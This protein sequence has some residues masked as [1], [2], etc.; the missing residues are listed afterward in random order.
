MPEPTPNPEPVRSDFLASRAAAA[1]QPSADFSAMM[2]TSQQLMAP[3]QA[4]TP[5]AAA[6][7][8]TPASG[9]AA[10]QPP[11]TGP[12]QYGMTPPHPAPDGSGVVTNLSDADYFKF[13]AGR[14]PAPALAPE[15]AAAQQQLAGGGA[16]G[17][18]LAAVAKDVGAGLVDAPRQIAGG[19]LD[20]SNNLMRFADGVVKQAEDAG[21]PNIYFQLL[22]KN[23]K[24]DPQVMSTEAFRQA[25]AEGKADV[26]QVPTTGQPDQVTG[27]I[28][29]AAS[30]FLASGAVAKAAGAGSLLADTVGSFTGVDASQPR[31]SNMI[32]AV[33]PNFVTDW[34]KAR[35][36]DEGTMLG[37]LKTALEYAGMGAA[38]ATVSKALKLAKQSGSEAGLTGTPAPTLPPSA[39]TPADGAAVPVPG[40]SGIPG[41]TPE[42]PMAAGATQ[43]GAGAGGAI[44][45]ATGPAEGGTATGAQP[46][47]AAGP[48]AME[49]KPDFQN[50]ALRFLAGETGENPVRVNLDML[51]TADDVKGMIAEMSA[52]LPEREVVTWA[53]TNAQARALGLNPT[54][55]MAGN[56]EGTGLSTPQ[57]RAAAML[58]TAMS[59]EATRLLQV[60]GLPGA[61]AEDTGAALRA[62]G[63][64]FQANQVMAGFEASAGR[65]LN[66]LGQMR[67]AT[68]D[69]V[70][71][72]QALL[73]DDGMSGGVD[74]LMGRLR[75]MIDPETGRLD[76]ARVGAYLAQVARGEAVQGTGLTVYYNVLLSNPA[77]VV[78]KFV[79][80]L[81]M[82]LW[83]MATTELAAR[84]MSGAVSPGESLQL[85]YGYMAA[86]REGFRLA[87]RAAVAGRSQFHGGESTLEGFR[88]RLD[89]LIDGAPAALTPGTPTMSGWQYLRAAMPTSWIGAVDD[90]AKFSHYSAEVNR[91]IYRQGQ[92]QGLEGEALATFMAEQRAAPSQAVQQQAWTTAQQ[93]AFQ[94]PLTGFAGSLQNARDQLGVFGKV[95]LPFIKVPMNI[96]K[97]AYTNSPASYVLS[98]PSIR[99]E[100]EAGGATRDMALARMALGGMVA[101]SVLDMSVQGQITGAGPTDPQLQRAWRAAG[102]EPYSIKILGTWY[103]YNHVEPLALMTGIIA[104]T[105]DIMRFAHEQDADALAASLV[106]GVGSAALSKTYLEGLSTFFEALNSPQQDGSKYA[107]NLISAMATPPGVAALAS[108]L[109]PWVRA[110]HGL[111]EQVQAR[112][113]FLSQNLPPARTLWGD[114]ISA[115][116]HYMPPFSGSVAARML[117]PVTAVPGDGSEPI[118]QWIWAN[119][120][121]FPHADDGS[122]GLRKL[123][124]TQPFR[125]SPEVTV[126]MPLTNEAFDRLQVLAGHELKDPSTGLGAKDALNALVQGRYPDA[127]TQQQWNKSSTP[128]QALM[129]QKIV[130]KY[131]AAARG[132]LLTEYPDI[133]DSLRAAASGRVD[134]LTGDAPAAPVPK[135]TPAGRQAMPVI[136][137]Q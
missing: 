29:R 24:W 84:T 45:G 62:I 32:D 113:P 34:M 13:M 130:Q 131:Q 126:N 53:E 99:A 75:G 16:L 70:A 47:P 89:A 85:A 128:V 43:E 82:G 65:N 122:L 18:G 46:A 124:Q 4:A 44:P 108:G 135:P 60:A 88:P 37:H 41:A 104:D 83:N 33:A 110:H 22:D 19:L 71:A 105:M 132:Q 63:A 2:P 21:L 115:R 92:A 137:G 136:G 133:A 56:I 72:M 40:A 6:A 23:G 80:D 1:V 10:A 76:P 73:R 15:A 38:F 30:T 25:Q 111:M 77:T 98:S 94:E 3:G 69:D 64:A 120:Q 78:K 9:T 36:E 39:T 101:W 48:R 28:I 93:L 14:P 5:A 79:S 51:Q 66:I 86:Q 7:G 129:V 26:F 81:G 114:P 42:P 107:F 112:L 57:L 17:R 90:W 11:A 50:L 134:Q 74:A 52:M 61:T 117:S 121:A 119:R 59:T 127:S 68:P 12:A 58:N 20:Y 118:D 103:G 100:L 31:L 95:L 87:G 35:P 54:D 27:S 96:M 106:F 8:G 123:Q 67:R 102:N 116:D 109:D 125:L 91:L 97:F 49:V 55:L